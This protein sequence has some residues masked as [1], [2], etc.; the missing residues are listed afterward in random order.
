MADGSMGLDL[1]K[2]FFQATAAAV[3]A[4]NRLN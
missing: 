1:K 4:M 3:A 2:I